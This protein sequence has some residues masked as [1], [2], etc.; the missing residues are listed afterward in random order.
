MELV[1]TTPVSARLIVAAVSGFP[2]R[3]GMI[4]AK[5]TYRFDA[6]GPFDLATAEPV[7]LLL[8]DVPTPLGLLPR[9]DLPRAD[10]AF[11]VIVL[12]Q[13][14]APGGK[15]TAQM[16]VKI[17]VGPERRELLVTGD[18]VWEGTGKDR[19]IGRAAPFTRMP[20]TWDRAFGGSADVLVDKDSP[21]TV[22]DPVNR[23]G[24]GFDHVRQAEHLRAMLTPPEG[25]PKFDAGRP[26]PNLENPAAPI[27][28]WDDAPRPACWATVPMDLGLHAQRG[29]EP[30]PD[31]D[32]FPGT[33]VKPALLHRAHPDWVIPVPPAGSPVVLDGL[34]P[35]DL[36]AFRIHP[37]QV[38]ADWTVGTETGVS[39]LAPQMLVILP[40][41][42]R[43]TLT[44][45]FVTNAF[46]RPEVERSIRLRLAEGWAKSS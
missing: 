38:L 36:V 24:K 30:Q 34:T 19:R 27:A 17:R 9:D 4:A 2:A 6:T 43:Y 14:H 28:N 32:G 23:L 13:A 16:Q 10:P 44:Y 26:L 7:A 46:F 21:V 5:A 45:R 37:L 39:E 42:R 11:E 29:M 18:R 3:F 41:Q 15:P 33:E 22:S 12:G 1:N 35:D 31:A 25:Y 20:L 8:I 40:E